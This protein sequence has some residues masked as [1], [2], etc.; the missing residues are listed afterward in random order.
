M[1]WHIV[2]AASRGYEPGLRAFLNSFEHYHSEY[3]KQIKVHILGLELSSE[4][5]AEL[6]VERWG[7]HSYMQYVPLDWVEHGGQRNTAW[8][9]KIPRFKYGAE[10]QDIVMLADADMFFCS[11]IE[12]WFKIAETGLIVA[13]SNGS[14]VRYHKG[15]REK[16]KLPVP[17]FYNYKTVCSVPTVMDTSLHGQVWLD[18]YEHKMAGGEGADFDLQNIFMTIHKKQDQIVAL[19]SQQT[20]GIHHFMLKPD[21]RVIRVDGRMVTRDGLEVYIVHGKWW[22]DGW[23]NNLLVKMEHFCKGNAVCV[24][25]AADS[26]S[27]LKEEFERWANAGLRGS[28]HSRVAAGGH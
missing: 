22:Q 25:G 26:R 20:T 8:S 12:H 13:G 19:P 3:P 17:D 24:R 10:L 18:L 21:S 16:Y 28:E 15:F 6:Q 23:Y 14:N 7:E 4:F 5:L 9:T 2:V 27:I 1:G 11:N